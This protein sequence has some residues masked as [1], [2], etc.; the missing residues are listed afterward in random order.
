M[1]ANFVYVVI[2]LAIS[3][4][5]TYGFYSFY[6]GDNKILLTAG[7]MIFLSVTLLFSFAL[8]F[9]ERARTTVLVR[10]VSGIMSGV[11]LITNRDVYIIICGLLL[12]IY[13]LILYSIVR[14]KQ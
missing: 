7:S 8:K 5:I 14:A 10:T 12:L 11:V 4:L 6:E 3:A 2:A 9:K 13:S 1:K